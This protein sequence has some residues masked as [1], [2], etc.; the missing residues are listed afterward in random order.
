M[1]KWGFLLLAM[2]FYFG[3]LQAQSDPE[4]DSIQAI[5]KEKFATGSTPTPRTL[6][7]KQKW[8]CTAFAATGKNKQSQHYGLSFTLIES[9]LYEVNFS[10][11][12]GESQYFNLTT[13]S[14]ERIVYQRDEEWDDT[15]YEQRFR[16]TH[17]G[18]I[19]YEQR[20][21]PEGIVLWR[22]ICKQ[23]M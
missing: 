22:A 15:R 12:R 7:I 5:L 20:R 10:Q 21:E 19:V 9:D 16:V 6:R 11:L 3:P 17:E 8:S 1:K 23:R 4:R 2:T 18:N 13:Y 14:L